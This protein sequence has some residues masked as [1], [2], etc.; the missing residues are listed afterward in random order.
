M[1]PDRQFATPIFKP[2]NK[3]PMVLPFK[4]NLFGRTFA[5]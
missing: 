5:W 1:L 3:I 4:W 2:V